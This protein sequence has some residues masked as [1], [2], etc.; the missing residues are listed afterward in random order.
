MIALCFLLGGLLAGSLSLNAWLTYR[1]VRGVEEAAKSE[2][3]STH[4]ESALELA[5]FELEQTRKA[6]SATEARA[7]ALEEIVADEINDNP[8]ADL[9]RADVRSRLL[10]AAKA[11]AAADKARTPAAD[12]VL[13]AREP[14][15]GPDTASV[16]AVDGPNV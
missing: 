7:A 16:S 4:F 6:L 11:W 3:G 10:R 12:N 8:N 13:A 14:E 2:I 1:T 9:D 5:R 15:A